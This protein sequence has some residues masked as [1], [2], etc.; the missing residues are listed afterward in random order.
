MTVLVIK[1]AFQVM[2]GCARRSLRH[3][4]LLFGSDLCYLLRCKK[5]KQFDLNNEWKKKYGNCILSELPLE[6]NKGLFTI[7]LHVADRQ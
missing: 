6:I 4:S 3:C 5:K 7:V 1:M 2:A